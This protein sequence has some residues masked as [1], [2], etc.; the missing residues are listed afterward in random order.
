MNNSIIVNQLN[1]ILINLFKY[2]VV[3]KHM[4]QLIK[5]NNNNNNN[6]IIIII[7]IK[8]NINNYYNFI[9]NNFYLL[10]RKLFNW[11]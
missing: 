6:N 4:D 11:K 5:T 8:L 1:L 7:I 2:T 10:C 9:I 3:K